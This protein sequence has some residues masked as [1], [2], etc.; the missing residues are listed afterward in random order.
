MDSSGLSS[1]YFWVV[2]DSLG[3]LGI[4]G[5]IHAPTVCFWSVWYSKFCRSRSQ[6]DIG[7]LTNQMSLHWLQT[8][9]VLS[10]HPD[11]EARLIDYRWWLYKHIIPEINLNYDESD[12]NYEKNCFYFV[13]LIISISTFRTSTVDN[14]VF[15]KLS[16]ASAG[17]RL[18]LFPFDPPTHPPNHPPG[19]VVETQGRQLTQLQLINV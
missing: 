6:I 16:P 4:V 10:D 8:T 15:A 7:H 18:A 12:K 9:A 13:F 1:G 17:L 14:I 3:W 5:S 19:I 11:K 2:R